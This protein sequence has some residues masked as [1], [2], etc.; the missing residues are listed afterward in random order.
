MTLLEM[1]EL[2][3]I[4]APLPVERNWKTCLYWTPVQGQQLRD[5]LNG[6]ASHDVELSPQK[7]DI[8]YPH[9]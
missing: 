2:A 9:I 6:S 4:T 3:K 5:I 8:Q 1:L 7:G